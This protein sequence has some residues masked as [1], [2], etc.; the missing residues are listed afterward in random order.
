ML[1]WVFLAIATLSQALPLPQPVQLRPEMPKT[2]RTALA[3]PRIEAPNPAQHRTPLPAGYLDLAT[4]FLGLDGCDYSR[5]YLN[6]EPSLATDDVGNPVVSCAV[7]SFKQAPDIIAFSA[8]VGAAG[9]KLP[10]TVYLDDRDLSD[11]TFRNVVVDVI[12]GPGMSIAPGL[13]DSLQ[14]AL[15]ERGFIV[16][17]LGYTGTRHGTLFPKPNLE[18]AVG[19][20]ADYLV[21]LR[22]RCQ[23]TKLVL[24]GESLG[25]N[26]VTR[27]AGSV[28][29]STLDAVAL[30]LPLVF[31]PD[32]ALANFHKIF[33][34]AGLLPTALQ[35]R[36]IAKPDA[37]WTEGKTVRV[38]SEELFASFFPP[39]ARQEGLG[40]LLKRTA[41]IRTLLAYGDVD[42]RVGVQEINAIG[43]FGTEL[44]KLKLSPLNHSMN[45]YWAQLITDGVEDLI[46]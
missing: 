40:E 22:L 27:A 32:A 24:L 28:P 41:G 2:V 34:K 39:K 11:G 36:I 33:A 21:R 46:R 10:V 7:W 20:I 26:I 35:V 43:V 17:K 6:G 3:P 4:A 9:A 23:T 38:S 45:P 13:N 25:G 30:V 5:S 16:V 12:G 42:D 14:I 44:R 29:S 15:A 37:P 31:S 18:A 8:S 1:N 19:Q